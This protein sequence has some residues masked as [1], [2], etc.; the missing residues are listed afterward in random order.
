MKLRPNESVSLASNSL[1]CASE[2]QWKGSPVLASESAT[3]DEVVREARLESE[4]GGDLL[5]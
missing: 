1:A 4:V 2:T 5:R 3:R